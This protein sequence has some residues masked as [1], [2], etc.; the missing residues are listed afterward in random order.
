MRRRRFTG[1][2]R[3][4]KRWRATPQLAA[5][6]IGNVVFIIGLEPRKVLLKG[7]GVLTIGSCFALEVR[8]ALAAEGF[9]T[10]PN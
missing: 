1:L 4:R 2:N 6:P 9:P 10:Y 5:Q 8:R 3:A 7:E